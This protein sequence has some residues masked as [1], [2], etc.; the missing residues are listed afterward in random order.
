L[1][2]ELPDLRKLT[3]RLGDDDDLLAALE[4]EGVE[5]PELAVDFPM[6]VSIVLPDR[7]AATLIG[8]P[9]LVRT[10]GGRPLRLSPGVAFPHSARS[11]GDAGPRPCSAWPSS[12][13]ARRCWRATPGRAG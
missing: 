4:V 10:V 12:R 1:D 11:G 13:P 6:S 7:T 5:P 9:Y 3:L 2:V 8:D